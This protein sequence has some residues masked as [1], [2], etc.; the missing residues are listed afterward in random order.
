MGVT[1]FCSLRGGWFRKPLQMPGEPG[2]RGQPVAAVD[3]GPLEFVEVAAQVR[4]G[5]EDRGLDAGNPA[6]LTVERPGCLPKPTRQLLRLQ[7]GEVQRVLDR[8]GPLVTEQPGGAIVGGPAGMA[9][10]LDE[11]EATREWR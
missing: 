3:A 6:F 7:V 5:E 8:A 4:R 2:L 9:L 11:E 10:D 1:L